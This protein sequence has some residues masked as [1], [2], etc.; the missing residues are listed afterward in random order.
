MSRTAETPPV[1]PE[2]P[3]AAHAER[4]EREGSAEHAEAYRIARDFSEAVRERGGQSLLVGGCVRDMVLGAMPKDYDMEV[5]GLPPG[6]V[7]ELAEQVGSVAEVGK[8]YGV[9]KLQ[10]GSVDLDISLP[11][12]DSKVSE[13][14]TG[15]EVNTDPNLSIEDA[16]RRRDFTINAVGADL[17]TGELHDPFGGLPDL[18]ERRL[19]VVD[20]ET[21]V[22]D[23]LRALRAIQ[24]A[25]RFELD[26]DPESAE[27]IRSMVP[28]LTE[29][30]GERL[31]AEWKKLLLQSPRPS[32]GLELGMELGLFDEIHP[33][34]PALVDVP[35]NPVWH[36]EGDVWRHTCLVVDEAAELIR[37]KDLSG[38]EAEILML[39]AVSHD[40][41][42]PAVTEFQDGRWTALGHEHEGVEP[43]RAFLNDL[44]IDN[45]TKAR[46]LKLVELH[47]MPRQLIR[48][49]LEYG[50]PVKDGSVRRLAM[51]LHPATIE[52]L[53][54]I[55]EADQRGRGPFSESHHRRGDA[56]ILDPDHVT[57]WLL[58]RARMLEVEDGKP[59]DIVT[60][61][62]LIA[63]G[64]KPGKHFG[65]VIRAA[66]DLRDDH[67][68][69]RDQILERIRAG[70]LP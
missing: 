7:L 49:L 33:Q 50:K 31:Q 44:V 38:Q 48:P 1:F 42:K 4:L 67:G 15:F 34:L 14:H 12:R 64:L 56:L 68:L 45:D 69:G 37:A 11:R 59:A 51:A 8:A 28:S 21:F 26:L 24:F 13:G 65:E 36:P 2:N 41:G 58:N 61:K 10:R 23:P 62:D 52:Q 5:R 70:M 53:A 43:A 9:L 17:L 30:P 19:R 66:N 47:M 6:D 35:Q 57:G 22:D 46:V 54:L 32:R 27:V 20:P 16:A 18:A 40:F 60:G 25:A 3:L 39:T 63:L 29:L 55:F